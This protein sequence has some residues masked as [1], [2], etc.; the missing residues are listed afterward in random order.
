MR[1]SAFHLRRNSRYLLVVDARNENGVDLDQD[2]RA[3]QSLQCSQLPLQQ[4]GRAILA[5]QDALAVPNPGINARASRGI[6]GVDGDGQVAQVQPCQLGRMLG[7]GKAVGRQAEQQVGVLRADQAQRLQGGVRVGKGI[8]RTRDADHGHIL[9]P[10]HQPIQVGE[11]LPR[12]KYN[13]RHAG[14]TFIA[15]I[16]APVTEVA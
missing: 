10:L 6:E 16:E 9:A 2:S 1:P 11:R 4:Q 12:R 7:Q 13:A 3:T 5:A 15:A 14:A 8:T